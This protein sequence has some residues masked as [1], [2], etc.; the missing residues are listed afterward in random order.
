MV[1][2]L[3]RLWGSKKILWLILSAQTGRQSIAKFNRWASPKLPLVM[4]QHFVLIG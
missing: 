4:T 3:P 2:L 1:I